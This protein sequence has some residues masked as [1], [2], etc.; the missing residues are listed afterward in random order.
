MYFPTWLF[1]EFL[2]SIVHLKCLLSLV[3]VPLNRLVRRVQLA[4]SFSHN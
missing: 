3:W 4:S 2:S 1:S